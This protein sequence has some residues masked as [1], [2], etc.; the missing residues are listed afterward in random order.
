MPALPDAT[1][2]I[3]AVEDNPIQARALRLLLAELGYDLVGVAASAPA[4]RQQFEELG[5]D[6]LLL[7]IRLKGEEDGIDLALQLNA[8]RPVP[9][10][11]VTSMQDRTTFERARAAGPF[12]F[13]AKPY[14]AAVLGR[15]IELAVVNFA[16]TQGAAPDATPQEGGLLV[17]DSLFLRENNHLVR[18]PYASL[19]WVQADDSYCHL[20][21]RSG[22]KHTLKVS[23]RELES[24]L[25]AGRFVRVRRG[26]VVQAESIEDI[27]LGKNQLTVGGQTVGIG[28]TY[29]EELLRGLNLIG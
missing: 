25:P 19:L 5:P 2:R 17:R 6:L 12:A 18:V 16:R 24:R 9:L 3:L 7:D 11:F 21:T 10:I 1:L 14:E 22:R 15:A 13:L 27:D 28:R 26:V 8:E 23:L 20:H 29:R 4:A